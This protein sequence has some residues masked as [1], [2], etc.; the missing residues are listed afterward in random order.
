M[1]GH[2]LWADVLGAEF[3]LSSCFPAVS[4]LF[5]L[6]CDAMWHLSFCPLPFWPLVLGGVQRMPRSWRM[7][8]RRRCPSPG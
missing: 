5:P 1:N 8:L 6:A 2:D 3:Q 7:C 4:M